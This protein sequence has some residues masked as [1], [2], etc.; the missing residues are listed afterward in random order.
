MSVSFENIVA[1]AAEISD[2]VVRTPTVYSGAISAAFG[3]D[4]FLKLEVLQRT[5]S[6]KDR[7]ALVK[8]LSLTNRQKKMASSQFPQAIMHKELRIM[9]SV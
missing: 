1:A 9:P 3:A 7:G 5:G 4:I 6:F 8:L 2:V